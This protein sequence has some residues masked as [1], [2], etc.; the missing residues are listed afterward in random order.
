MCQLCGG[1]CHPRG[2]RVGWKT[3]SAGPPPSEPLLICKADDCYEGE[4][5]QRR[6]QRARQWNKVEPGVSVLYARA[7]LRE[8]KQRV[9]LFAHSGRFLIVRRTVTVVGSG[10]GLVIATA[11]VAGIFGALAVSPQTSLIWAR[12]II[13]AVRT[14]LLLLI[15]RPWIGGLLVGGG[16]FLH[17]REREW[18]HV[19]I[20]VPADRDRREWAIIA[21]PSKEDELTAPS[22]EVFLSRPTWHSV[23][24]ASGCS[25]LG[26]IDW[27]LITAG[28]L[29]NRFGAIVI[30]TLGTL[31]VG[32]L[33][34]R[35]IRADVTE[36]GLS[37]RPVWW[38]FTSRYG[39]VL[40]GVTIA[41]AVIPLLVTGSIGP[42]SAVR[43]QQVVTIAT[44]VSPAWLDPV[45]ILT[46]GIVGG[47][48]VARRYALIQS[49]RWAALLRGVTQPLSLVLRVRQR[50]QDGSGPR[51]SSGD[52]DSTADD[53]TNGSD[54]NTASETAAGD[55]TVDSDDTAASDDSDM[56][57][58]DTT[59]GTAS[60]RPSSVER[61]DLPADKEIAPSTGAGDAPPASYQL[62]R[63]QAF[64]RDEY[65]CQI[66]G[67]QGYPHA[68]R[69]L[70]GWVS[71]EDIAAE[72]Y[73]IDN[74]VTICHDCLQECD[75]DE[76]AQLATLAKQRIRE[77][78]PTASD[79]ASN[80]TDNDS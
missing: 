28:L 49:G 64:E 22:P 71:E 40:G 44:Q 76:I 21:D 70:A 13:T 33:L 54:A 29:G 24:L 42:L 37:V 61:P 38:V 20:R 23:A 77:D 18:H 3:E 6:K 69:G 63:E 58:P 2:D 41:G 31:S 73:R 7:L 4:E 5:R 62:A 32:V 47:W 19:N 46:P 26:G 30:W 80:D 35:S 1:I 56:Q 39:S 34:K 79:E 66:C 43:I 55:A 9:R 68:K 17:T 53:G 48:Y 60:A 75:A 78:S 45:V 50:W 27:V 51:H 57:S 12:T 72:D 65:T 52:S 74:I 14:G 15:E 67:E 10:I 11:L 36:Y 59:D 16:Y 8:F 25:L